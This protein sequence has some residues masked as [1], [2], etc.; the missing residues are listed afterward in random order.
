VFEV[1]LEIDVGFGYLFPYNLWTSY[2]TR[3]SFLQEHHRWQQL[4]LFWQDF[5]CQQLVFPFFFVGF[6]I[7]KVSLS[8]KEIKRQFLGLFFLMHSF[9]L[10]NII[11]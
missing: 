4:R 5:P 8:F 10:T 11:F 1:R 9:T 3:I 2:L 7:D 6:L